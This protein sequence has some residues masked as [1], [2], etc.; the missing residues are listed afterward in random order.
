LHQRQARLVPGGPRPLSRG[1]RVRRTARAPE[2]PPGQSRHDLHRAHGKARARS[3][4]GSGAMIRRLS[5]LIAA[6]AACA[7][8]AA[9][10]QAA[11]GALDRTKPPA[12]GPSTKFN[13]PTVARGTLANGVAVQVVEHH[14]LPLVHVTLIIGGGSRLEAEQPGLAGF[15]ARML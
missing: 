5:A 10:A 4:E 14:G 9:C 7:P 1:H 15:T 2:V 8:V 12:L 6:V 11:A 3:Q 13:L